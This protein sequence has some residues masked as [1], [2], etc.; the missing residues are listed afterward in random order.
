MPVWAAGLPGNI[1]PLRRAARHNGFFPVDLEHPDQLADIVATVTDLRR[2]KTTPYDIAVA[3]PA[4]A[5]PT[6]YAEA[7]ATWWLTEFPP[8]TVSLDQVR[9]V[10][11]D[12]PIEP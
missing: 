11:R 1:K 2:R 10:I 3:L 5:D 4:G 12:G 6:P 9:G 7:G 8:E